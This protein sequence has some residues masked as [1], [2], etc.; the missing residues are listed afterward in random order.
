MISFRERGP[1]PIGI[2]S[3]IGITLGVLFAFYFKRIPFFANNYT[4]KAQFADAAGLNPENEVRVAG[5]KVGK[6]TRVELLK[7]RVL[8]TM[9]IENGVDI[10]KHSRAAISLKTILGTKF[11]KIN[12]LG[13][14]PFFKEGDT[15]PMKQT[16]IP[17]E[18]YQAANAGV[19]I[20]Q[21]IDAKALNEGLK[22]LAEITD[23]PNRNL[24]RT[25]EGSAEVTQAIASQGDAL[26]L[27]I[28]HGEEL[29]A[30]L[31]KSSPDIQAIITNGDKALELLARRRATVQQ[32]LRNTDRLLASFGDLLQDNRSRIDRILNDLHSVLLIVDAKL[33]DLEQAVRL[34]GPSSESISRIAWRGRWASICV[35]ALQAKVTVSGVPF[36]ASAGTGP[37]GPV[38]CSP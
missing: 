32:L 31:D 18:I 16:S 8:V 4:L 9:Q 37:T 3:I 14:G 5:I 7:D 23:D 6:V 11:V 24:A 1:I 22:A 26:Q 30:A 35:A 28:E 29:L 33:A 12:G 13:G 17:F 25:L 15:I 34:L 21:E 19:Q 36:Q 27:L 38:N 10:P 20:L 2:A